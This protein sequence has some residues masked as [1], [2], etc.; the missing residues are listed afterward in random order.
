MKTLKFK[1]EFSLFSSNTLISE[2]D[3]EP[4]IAKHTFKPNNQFQIEHK[5]EI[6]ITGE[7]MYYGG[8]DVTNNTSNSRIF[9]LTT[10]FWGKFTFH[11]ND[12]SL[13]EKDLK[14]EYNFDFSDG[15][16]GTWFVDYQDNFIEAISYG[17][18]KYNWNAGD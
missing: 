5:G 12:R 1:R 4:Y 15:L 3:K 18:L 6:I 10:S 9:S 8:W 14:E 2:G 13:S 17:Y 7:S 16:L 11:I